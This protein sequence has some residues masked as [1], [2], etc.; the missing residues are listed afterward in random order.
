MSKYDLFLSFL[1]NMEEIHTNSITMERLYNELLSK[2][3]DL[4][5]REDIKR[6]VDAAISKLHLCMEWDIC[7]MKDIDK[8]RRLIEKR[9]RDELKQDDTSTPPAPTQQ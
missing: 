7:I 2:A 6:H 5:N 3:A 1:N 9:K 4:P 8:A